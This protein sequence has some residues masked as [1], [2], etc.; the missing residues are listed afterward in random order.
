[1]VLAQEAVGP[2]LTAGLA[3]VAAVQVVCEF[4]THVS[5][6]A[7]RAPVLMILIVLLQLHAPD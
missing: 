5:W 6:M 1:M 7:F 3:S 2:A 4:S